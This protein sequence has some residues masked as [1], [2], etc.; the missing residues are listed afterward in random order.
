MYAAC[1]DRLG[2]LN[3]IYNPLAGGLLT[4]KHR[5]ED[6]SA[7]GTR[8]DKAIYRDRYWNPAQFAALEQLRT[9]ATAAGLSLVELSFRWLLGRPLTGAML[10]GA[11]SPGQLAANLA[12]ID[13]RPLD[14][15]TLAACANV[16]AGLAGAAPDYNR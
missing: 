1:A 2:L 16:W 10:L 9:V 8:F 6:T 4:G 7:S 15:A 13:D 14:A 5:L 3:I 12:A 11:S